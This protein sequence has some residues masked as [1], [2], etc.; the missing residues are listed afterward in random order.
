M[1]DDAPGDVIGGYELLHVIGQGGMAVVWKARSAEGEHVAIKRLQPHL[2]VESTFRKMFV[3]E[4]RVGSTLRHRHIVALHAAGYTQDARPYHV[5]QWVHGVD[6][7]RFVDWHHDDGRPTPWRLVTRIMA[8]ALRGLAA[9]HDRCDPGG[10]LSPVYHR[11]VSPGNVLCDVTGIAR[12]ADFGVAKAMDRAPMT[13]PG[14]VKGKLGYSA[15]EALRGAVPSVQSDLWSAGVVFWEALTA[16]RLFSAKGVA[17]LLGKLKA[18]IPSLAERRPDV[19]SEIVALVD[20]LLKKQPDDRPASAAETAAWLESQ[21]DESSN[22]RVLAR[23][24]TQTMSAPSI[25]PPQ[26]EPTT[27][28]G[29]GDVEP[30]ASRRAGARLE[31]DG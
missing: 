25:G 16:E 9:A 17:E 31:E 11:D 15:P 21:L 30:I 14:L 6:L 24:I 27:E 3:E 7:A 13:A 23:A 2:E 18:P 10:A 28:I 20:D 4:G 1:R 22:E 12:L 26:I 8:H 29:I 19:P 5:L